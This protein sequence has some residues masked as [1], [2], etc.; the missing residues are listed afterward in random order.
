M[1]GTW[2]TP[3]NNG[4]CAAAPEQ[5]ALPRWFRKSRAVRRNDCRHATKRLAAAGRSG[6]CL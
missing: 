4:K 3:V 2:L 5:L 1:F 6:L